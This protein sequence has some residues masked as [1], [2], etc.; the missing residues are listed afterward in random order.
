M[1]K[2]RRNVLKLAAHSPALFA[3]NAYAGNHFKEIG[4]SEKTDFGIID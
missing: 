3:L 4:H 2:N 1:N